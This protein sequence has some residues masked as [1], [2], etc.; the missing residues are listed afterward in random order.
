M[1]LHEFYIGKAFDAYEYFGAHITKDGVLFRVYA[2]CA[3]KIELIGEFNDWDGSEDERMH[4][5]VYLNVYRKM[6]NRE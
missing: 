3:E 1:N 2:P 5:A 6:Q 4:K